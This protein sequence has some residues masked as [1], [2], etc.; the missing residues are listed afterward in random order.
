MISS[1]GQNLLQSFFRIMNCFMCKYVDNEIVKVTIEDIT[2]LEQMI[3][4]MQLFAL[5]WSVGGSTDYGGRLKFNETLKVI[6][7]KK[8]IPLLSSYYDFF[9]NLK[10]KEFEPWTALYSSFEINQNLSYHEIIIPTKDS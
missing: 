2:E 9:F 10:N 7:S 3:L 8:G 6:A 1:I 5:T 4:S